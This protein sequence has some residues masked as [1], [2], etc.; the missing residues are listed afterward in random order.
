MERQE[1]LIEAQ[2][3]RLRELEIK[4]RPLVIVNKS[5]LIY[6]NGEDMKAE[7]EESSRKDAK[8]QR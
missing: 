7:T 1:R 8:A 2:E 6:F 3:K 5:S 4:A